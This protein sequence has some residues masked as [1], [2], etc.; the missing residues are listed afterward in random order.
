[1]VLAE[2]LVWEERFEGLVLLERL[3][4][5]LLLVWMLRP[6]LPVSCWALWTVELPCFVVCLWRLEV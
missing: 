4:R 5:L 1:M 6:F 2:R 3:L